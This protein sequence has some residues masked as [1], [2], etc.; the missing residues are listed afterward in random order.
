MTTNE[1]IGQRLSEA[2][3]REARDLQPPPQLFEQVSRRRMRLGRRHRQHRSVAMLV[4]ALVIAG[5]S[6][7]AVNHG[8]GEVASR[9]VVVGSSNL[10]PPRATRLLPPTTA[11]IAHLTT[12]DTPGPRSHQQMYLGRQSVNPPEILINTISG[13]QQNLGPRVLSKGNYQS[14][15]H[16][17]LAGSNATLA[18]A[19][20]NVFAWWFESDGTEVD[21]T[22]SHITASNLILAV[23]DATSSRGSSPSQG[24]I[25]PEPL[26]QTLRLVASA[27]SIQAPSLENITYS[28]GA[29]SASLAVISGLGEVFGSNPTRLMTVS[30][31]PALLTM[32]ANNTEVL[33]WTPLSGVSAQLSTTAASG[34]CSVG[35]MATGIR[36]VTYQQLEAAVRQLGSRAHATTSAS[37]S[38]VTAPATTSAPVNHTGGQPVLKA[39]GPDG[40]ALELDVASSTSAETCAT[41]HISDPGVPADPGGGKGSYA[42]QPL[43]VGQLPADGELGGSLWV[44]HTGARYFLIVGRAEGAVSIVA[45]LQGGI[46]HFMV[47]QGWWAAAIPYTDTP[48][49]T[50][51]AVEPTGQLGATFLAA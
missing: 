2:L 14:P 8:G 9:Q 16:L 4:S 10:T 41:L 47:N 33:A 23:K 51:T 17:R 7:F 22:G 11:A 3:Q 32:A 28:I 49:F 37:Q 24:L 50:A 48:G 21:V 39:P 30:G 26:P 6:F 25:L 13:S 35:S 19:G 27:E 36:S 20:G 15:Q 45:H 5:G 38:S 43:C 12:V 29:C 34:T 44:S 40:T 18:E 1:D 46:T 31:H 42:A